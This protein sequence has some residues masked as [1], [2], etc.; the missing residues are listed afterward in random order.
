M[1]VYLE[2]FPEW[3]KRGYP[4][5]SIADFLPVLEIPAVEPA[6]LKALIAGPEKV[7]LV[8]LRDRE[9]IQAL[10]TIAGAMNL[11]LENLMAKHELIPKGSRVVLVDTSGAQYPIA[12][13][14]LVKQNF[15][16]VAGL[17]GGVNAW[18]EAGFPV[19]K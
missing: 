2:G 15:A 19:T 1:Y 8:D 4:V 11:P 10:G 5:E 6:E 17:R 3:K 12:G 18:I 14:Y 16:K 9:D 7:V 13:R